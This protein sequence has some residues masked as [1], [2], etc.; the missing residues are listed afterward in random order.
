MS[1]V[2]GPISRVNGAIEILTELLVDVHMTPFEKVRIN[3][4]AQERTGVSPYL[5]PNPLGPCGFPVI[6]EPAPY[7]SCELAVGHVGPCG[8]L[9]SVGRFS[10]GGST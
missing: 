7:P 2:G 1:G 3:W 8:R 5:S 9:P 6:A 10:D 4:S